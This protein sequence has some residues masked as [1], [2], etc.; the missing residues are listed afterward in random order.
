MVGVQVKNAFGKLFTA[1]GNAVAGSAKG[2][3]PNSLVSIIPF[4]FMHS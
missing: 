3:G 4:K 1:S 2:P